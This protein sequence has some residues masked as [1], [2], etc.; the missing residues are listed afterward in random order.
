MFASYQNKMASSVINRVRAKLRGFFFKSIR[1]ELILGVAV[2]HAVLMSLFIVDLVKRQEYFLYR[3]TESQANAL[4]A[5]MAASGN[6]WI[7]AGDFVGLKEIV[8]MYNNYP[9]L[10]FAMFVSPEGRVIGHSQTDLVGKYLTDG[11]SKRLLDSAKT[12][13][14]L[15]VDSDLVDCAVPMFAGGIFIGWARVA[16]N[17]D[18]HVKSLKDVMLNGALYIILA[19]IIGSVFAVFIARQMTSKLVALTNFSL[20]VQ[21][22]SRDIRADED[23]TDELSVLSKG[24]NRMIEAI[25]KTESS[26]VL[27][28]IQAET[29]NKTKNEFLANMSH[30][31]RTPMNG[32]IGMTSLL[33]DTDLTDVQRHYAG[34]IK[35][36]GESLLGLIND[37]LDFSKIEAGMLDLEILDFDLESLLDDFASTMA[38]KAHDKGVELL[39]AADLDVPTLLSGD[40][41]RL[42]QILANLTGNAVKFTSQGEVAVKVTRVLEPEVE[43]PEPEEARDK[44]CLLRFSVRDTGIGIPADKIDILFQQFTQV[45]ASTTRQYGGTG[46]GLAISKQLV[47][48]MGGEIGVKSV[49]DQGSEFWFTARFGVQ[50][51]EMQGV[52]P[53]CAELSGV[54]VLIIDDNA[55]NREILRVRFTSWGMRPEEANDG[56]SG[57]GALYR[58][59]G[60]NDPFRL[61]VVDMQM[62]G[63]D[64]KSVGL[65][66]KADAKIA[67]THLVMLTSLGARG[68][69]K[70]LHQIG[71]AAYVVKPVRHEELKVVLSQTLAYSAE[72]THQV[73][74]SRHTAREALPEVTNQKARILLA[75]DNITN[76]QVALGILKKLGLSADAVANGREAIM[77]LQTLPYDLVLMDVQMPEMDGLE[78]TKQIRNPQ[79]SILNRNI[80]II[81]MTA[82]AMQGDKDRCLAVGMNDYVTKPISPRILAETLEKWLPGDVTGISGQESIVSIQKTKSSM[83]PSRVIFDRAGLLERFMGDEEISKQIIQ[84]FLDDMPQQIK[85]LKRYIETGNA[86]S[87]ELQAHTIKGAAANV[88]GGSLRG[89]ASELEQACKAGELDSIVTRLEELE[90]AFAQLKQIIE[91]DP[92]FGS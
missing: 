88:G 82:H 61:A 58:A 46:L 16:I 86:T 26:L 49:V 23:G 50:T 74:L 6:S 75:E 90:A 38:F 51:E 85:A 59:L 60:E 27:A 68:E 80:P 69:A 55:T 13:Q 29:A 25:N 7:L 70:H 41:G 33:L 8:K 15:D 35:S 43:G 39:C 67:D 12:P 62:P 54:R 65:A 19:I 24:F 52:K 71:F 11:A 37:I 81:A 3:E 56:P 89:L 22:G 48:L 84:I 91:Q 42:R 63:M 78:A 14:M 9:G 2:V 31:I 21:R 64:G 57:L 4:A 72:G 28:R 73:I 18:A 1:R 20:M 44:S 30:E 87:G 32:V 47:E 40:P 83:L 53:L 17:H 79:S 45:D 92:L 5:A 10:E 77:S 66:V 76:Q 34:T 36:S